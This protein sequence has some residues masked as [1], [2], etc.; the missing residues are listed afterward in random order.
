MSREFH[1]VLGLIL[2]LGALVV[3]LASIL[4]QSVVVGTIY[5]AMLLAATPI[6]VYAFCSKCPCRL[7]GCGHVFPGK[8]TR[9]LPSRTPGRYTGLDLAGLILLLV[10][11]LA[12]P[13]G[14]LWGNIVL[15]V[16]F[17]VLVVL[18][19]IE[20]RLYVCPQCTN[21]DCPLCTSSS[22]SQGQR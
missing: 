22:D 1:G 13:Q 5:L 3:G 21:A 16:V 9:L 15:A 17:W 14:W 19:I 11:L 20:I 2:V 12:F 10:L 7:D 4:G 6:M 18:G 8:L